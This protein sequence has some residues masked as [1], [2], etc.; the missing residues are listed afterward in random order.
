MRRKHL[1][2]ALTFAALAARPVPTQA[3]LSTFPGAGENGYVR[4]AP[5]SA[6]NVAL[7]GLST[8]HYDDGCQF[9]LTK[10][11]ASSGQPLW[12]RTVDTQVCGSAP[13]AV[14]GRGDVVVGGINP[15]ASEGDPGLFTVTQLAAETG[16]ELWRYAL[17][18][19]GELKAIH[20]DAMDNVLVA[21]WGWL[22]GSPALEVIKLAGATGTELWH[23][24]GAEFFSY[25]TS[26]AMDP[27][28]NVFVAGSSTAGWTIVKLDAARGGELWRTSVPGDLGRLSLAIDRVGDLVVAG[29]L[30]A[31]AG[32]CTFPSDS[33]AIKLAGA[34]GGELWRH[35]LPCGTASALVLDE[36]AD[37]IVGGEWTAFSVVRLAGAT[38]AE[39]WR[40]AFPHMPKRFS[41]AEALALTTGGDVIVAAR[42]GYRR[43][44]PRRFISGS[45][46]LARLSGTNGGTR[47]HRDLFRGGGEP[48][49]VALDGAGN[50]IA[51]GTAYH[52]VRYVIGFAAVKV[53]GR[54]GRSVLPRHQ[55]RQP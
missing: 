55:F 36:S 22:D 21:G 25:V 8:A 16:R 38:G 53:S 26:A 20:V 23:H 49:G 29:P 50:V 11:A 45:F 48:Q 43:R 47:W 51:A 19:G 39:R 14:N 33:A 12:L 28:G 6:G 34:N 17:P 18:V 15:S 30:G 9:T 41:A 42:N 4:L 31:P 24:D 2:M 1:A 13:M 5:D 10:L 40:H 46:T 3:W 54:S 37:V 35:A 32:S 7:V 27:N 52:P 44:G